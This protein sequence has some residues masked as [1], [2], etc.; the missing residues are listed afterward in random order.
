MSRIMT[1]AYS[2]GRDRRAVLMRLLSIILGAGVLCLSL[3]SYGQNGVPSFD[4]IWR[5]EAFRFVPPYMFDHGDDQGVIDGFNNPILRP[6]TVELLTEKQHSERNGRIY[7]NAST[8]CWP[9]GVPGVFGVRHI[10]ILQLPDE[11][12][13]I[14]F[15]D[16]QFR[17]IPLNQPHPNPVEP[18]WYGDSIGHFEGDT[19]VVDTIGFYAR[20][21]VMVDD[22]GTPASEALHVVER[23]RVLED[24]RQLQIDVTVDDPNVF[25]KPWSMTMNYNADDNML[26]ES[27][28]ARTIAT[29]SN[30]YQ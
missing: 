18:S 27:A 8:T 5:K 2:L 7:P 10:Q 9:W 25:K 14:Y 19:L 28:A 17:Q 16:Q 6:W 20:P 26:L 1:T 23:Y 4:G 11:I 21:Q 13:I 22:Y 30:S 29:G 3:P 12:K 24:G 15:N